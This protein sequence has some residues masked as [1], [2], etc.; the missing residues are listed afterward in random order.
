[1]LIGSAAAFAQLPAQPV[2]GNESERALERA[3]TRRSILVLL[4]G[5]Y[6]FEPTRER[7]AGL[8]ALAIG[9]E[10]RDQ[11]MD[12]LRVIGRSQ[13]IQSAAGDFV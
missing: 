1:M 3:L 12:R 11:C 2:S 10:K 4:H 9:A 6:E 5:S 7:R 8:Q 13:G